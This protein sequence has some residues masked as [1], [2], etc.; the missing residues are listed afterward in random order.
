M[1]KEIFKR[2]PFSIPPQPVFQ[3]T[4]YFFYFI[5]ERYFYETFG[6][7]V[8]FWI[9]L[10][11]TSSLESVGKVRAGALRFTGGRGKRSHC[12]LGLLLGKRG[13]PQFSDQAQEAGPTQEKGCSRQV[14][15]FG[16]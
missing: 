4:I 6:T 16:A 13:V 3:P 1:T 14:Y 5:K 15:G 11:R 7:V 8:S 9:F 10:P 12:P 2:K